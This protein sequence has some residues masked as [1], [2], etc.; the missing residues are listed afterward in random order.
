MYNTNGK[1]GLLSNIHVTKFSQQ[2]SMII[3]EIQLKIM[4]VIQQRTK[5]ENNSSRDIKIITYS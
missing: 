5:K 3:L 2:I 4:Y 1:Y